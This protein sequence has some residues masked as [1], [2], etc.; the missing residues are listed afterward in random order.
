MVQQCQ[1]GGAWAMRVTISFLPQEESKALTL[2][3]F[4]TELLHPR[5]RATVKP[6]GRKVIYLSTNQSLKAGRKQ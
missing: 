5:R 4:V 3:A 1:K 2:I 6:D